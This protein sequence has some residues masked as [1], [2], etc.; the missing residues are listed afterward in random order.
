MGPKNWPAFRSSSTVVVLLGLVLLCSIWVG[1][2]YKVQSERKMEL[3][4]AFRETANFARTF[5]E[6]AVRTIKGMDQIALFLKYQY[7]KEGRNLDIPR[8]V[9]EGRF[10]D[11]PFVLLSVMDGNGE[12]AVSSQVPFVGSNL[13][14]RDHFLIHKYVNRGLY[15]SKPVLGRSSGKWSIQ[16][17]RRV[18]K[19]DGSFDGV[20]A[21]SVDPYYFADYYK[22]VDIGK[23]STIA[24]VG[25][26]GNVRVQLADKEITVG[27]DLRQSGLMEKLLADE[28]GQFVEPGKVDSVKRIYS[29]RAL[30]DYPLI[31]LVGMSEEQVLGELN[32]RVVSYYWA[33][34]A[35][36]LL[37]V[38][39]VSTMLIA[40][41]RRKKTEAS[42]LTERNLLLTLINTIPDR[43]HIKK[44]RKSFC[45]KQCRSYF[46]PRRPF[47]GGSGG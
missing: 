40:G 47:T 6:H 23:N 41:V 19:P 35:L 24:L 36:S 38:L 42:L 2:Y 29:Y 10:A 20:V 43:V 28:V 9:S 3:D 15:I 1:L 16:L 37:I 31:V 26:D 11:Q 5:E 22:Q 27:G 12:L 39:L 25:R 7:E 46:G 32:R 33:C 30:R 45:V 13:K 14:D 17:T 34:G 18:N 4:S 21:V 44:Q 8:Y